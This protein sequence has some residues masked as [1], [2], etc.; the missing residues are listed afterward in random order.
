MNLAYLVG[1]NRCDW[2]RF[3]LVAPAAGDDE[4]FSFVLEPV[5]AAK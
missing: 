2:D 3:D 5:S 4:H 1:V